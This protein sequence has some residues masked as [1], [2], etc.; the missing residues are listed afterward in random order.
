[1]TKK[2]SPCRIHC[3]PGRFRAVHKLT[4][5]WGRK[6]V[7]ERRDRKGGAGSSH[8][9]L[10]RGKKTLTLRRNATPAIPRK[11]GDTRQRRHS[12][13]T[14][15]WKHI[16]AGA[17]QKE[18]SRFVDRKRKNTFCSSRRRRFISFARKE[19]RKVRVKLKPCT[20]Q[21]K[22]KHPQLL[23]ERGCKHRRSDGMEM[24]RLARVTPPIKGERIRRTTALLRGEGRAHRALERWLWGSPEHD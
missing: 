7:S 1:L 17:K 14:S 18:Q 11:G 16:G 10:S 19:G 6:R 8:E 2:H 13:L 24:R 4:G 3:G 15:P 22:E 21:G 20:V 5:K 12:P 9:W 23:K